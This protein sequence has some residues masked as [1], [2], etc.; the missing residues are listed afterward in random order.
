[1]FDFVIDLTLLLSH[2]YEYN[3]DSKASFVPLVHRGEPS[4]V[5]SALP[6]ST[7]WSRRLLPQISHFPRGVTDIIVTPST[8]YLAL[9]TRSNDIISQFPNKPTST[10]NFKGSDCCF[11]LLVLLGFILNFPLTHLPYS[12]QPAL[13]SLLIN[14]IS[15]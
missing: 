9:P 7:W 15:V 10:M 8:F 13:L 11:S 1:M 12:Y 14:H 4:S 3:L 5:T 2:S 6:S